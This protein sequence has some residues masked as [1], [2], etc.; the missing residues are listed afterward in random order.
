MDVDNFL[1]DQMSKLQDDVWRVKD[2]FKKGQIPWI[3]EDSIL[4]ESIEDGTTTKL[5]EVIGNNK[6]QVI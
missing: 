1:I 4:V 2:K 5:I 6:L 3:M